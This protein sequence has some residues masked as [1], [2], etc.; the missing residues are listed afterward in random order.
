MDL[1]NGVFPDHGDGA[2]DSKRN[3]PGL[4]ENG[5]SITTGLP[6]VDVTTSKPHIS[7]MVMIKPFE[8]MKIKTGKIFLVYDR[9]Y[10]YPWQIRGTFR[11][12]F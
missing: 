10:L 9:L 4:Q 5:R 11:T 7:V 2:T 1:W 3:Y 6:T 8:S 12:N